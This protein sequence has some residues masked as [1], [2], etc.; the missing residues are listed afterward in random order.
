MSAALRNYKERLARGIKMT[1]K[2]VRIFPASTFVAIVVAF[3]G[4][5]TIVNGTTEKIQ[6]SSTPDSAQATIDGSQTVTTPTT[7]ELSRGDEHTITFH[8][9][10]YQ[11]D[12]EKLTSSTSGW[13][14]G[15]LLVGGIVGAVADGETGAGKKLSSDALNIALVPLPPKTAAA[16]P[17]NPQPSQAKAATSEPSTHAAAS[18]TVAAP[19]TADAPSSKSLPGADWQAASPPL[20]Q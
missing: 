17:S 7:V 20:T 10:G 8:K 11:D 15:N 16:P 13:I 9:D 2:I 18:V 14:W 3:S 19:A 4:C 5:A 6:L 1:S 12:T